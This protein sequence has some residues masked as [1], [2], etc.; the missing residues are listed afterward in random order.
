MLA[1]E[2][3]VSLEL[4]VRVMVRVGY[5]RLGYETLGTKRFGYEMRA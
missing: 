5:R 3:G 2:S 4:G 1:S